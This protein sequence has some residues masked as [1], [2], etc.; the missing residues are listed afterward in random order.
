MH[1]L[2][3]RIGYNID[4]NLFHLLEDS[5]WPFWFNILSYL[6]IFLNGIRS[7]K[8]H[9]GSSQVIRSYQFTW[10]SQIIIFRPSNSSGL[11]PKIGEWILHR[12][13]GCRRIIIGT[14]L[15]RL[16]IS[17]KSYSRI[18]SVFGSPR[19]RTQIRWIEK[20]F[21]CQSIQSRFCQCHEC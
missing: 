2:V 15:R 12:K 11:S 5:S 10:S 19:I 6:F 7:Y 14:H 4:D 8:L 3:V 21:R 16:I 1:D 13:I 9:L 18:L 17:I 20:E